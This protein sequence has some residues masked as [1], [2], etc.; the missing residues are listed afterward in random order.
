MGIIYAKDAKK[1]R[2]PKK[3]EF[4]YQVDDYCLAD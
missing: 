3:W 4:F 2:I 1:K